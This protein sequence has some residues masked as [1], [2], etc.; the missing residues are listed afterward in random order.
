MYILDASL[1]ENEAL[2]LGTS[3]DVYLNRHIPTKSLN[4]IVNSQV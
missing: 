4:L 1:P 3:L 2:N